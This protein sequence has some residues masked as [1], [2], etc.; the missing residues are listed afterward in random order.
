M[1]LAVKLELGVI[2]GFV[3]TIIGLA[4]QG[5]RYVHQLEKKDQQQE[6]QIEHMQDFLKAKLDYTPVKKYYR[7]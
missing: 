5:L 4:W 7:K 6:T 2:L 3:G 1:E